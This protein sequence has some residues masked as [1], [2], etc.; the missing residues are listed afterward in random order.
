[1]EPHDSDTADSSRG[2]SQHS[3]RAHDKSRVR[4]EG[5]SSARTWVRPESQQS[6]AYWRLLSSSSSSA[7]D[8]RHSSSQASPLVRPE[9]QQY[10]HA[11][12]RFLQPFRRTRDESPDRS[13]PA[14]SHK[15]APSVGNGSRPPQS[16]RVSMKLRAGRVS[17]RESRLPA[18]VGI[19]SSQ[20]TEVQPSATISVADSIGRFTEALG[21][22]RTASASEQLQRPQGG[23]N[24]PQSIPQSDTS[25]CRS[26]GCQQGKLNLEEENE[27]LREECCRLTEE[28][29][30]RQE[31]LGRGLQDAPKPCSHPGYVPESLY[32]IVKARLPFELDRARKL[33]EHEMEDLRQQLNAPN[34]LR[35]DRKLRELKEDI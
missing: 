4:P 30:K 12:W 13:V 22:W 6:V 10:S 31:L 33:H 2:L 32:D 34:K 5:S 21:S 28:V 3:S 8:E 19:L 14:R 23:T 9:T 16:R 20:S 18:D 27:L 26:P 24:R 25:L 29:A 15:V 1:M 7:S 11:I 17:E 35:Q